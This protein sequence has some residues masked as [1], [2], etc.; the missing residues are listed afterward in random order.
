M[1]RAGLVPPAAVS[2]ALQHAHSCRRLAFAGLYLKKPYGCVNSDAQR[3]ARLFVF[4]DGKFRQRYTP[5]RPDFLVDA[6]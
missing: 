2:T 6:A 4:L 1:R 3:P 5:P